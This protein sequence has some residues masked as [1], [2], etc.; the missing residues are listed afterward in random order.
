MVGATRSGCGAGRGSGVAVCLLAFGGN[1]FRCLSL[2]I[3]FAVRFICMRGI[4]LL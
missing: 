3:G 4:L 2:G 1:G